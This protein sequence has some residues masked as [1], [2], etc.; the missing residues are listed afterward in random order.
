MSSNLTRRTFLKGLGALALSAVL[1]TPAL[2]AQPIM[3]AG[4]VAPTLEGFAVSTGKS[5]WF[6]CDGSAYNRKDYPELFEAL[7]QVYTHIAEQPT[8]IAEQPTHFNVPDLRPSFQQNQL[9][10]TSISF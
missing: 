1:P 9:E 3:P 4:V 5:Y 8:H 2:P 10:K 7:G 6:P